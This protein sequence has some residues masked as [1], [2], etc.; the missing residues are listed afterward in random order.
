M[1]LVGYQGELDTDWVWISSTVLGGSS[2]YRYTLIS[3]QGVAEV[4]DDVASATADVAFRSGV[5]R[6]RDVQL[7]LEETSAT[8]EGRVFDGVTI[9]ARTYGRPQLPYRRI[10]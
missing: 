5:Y 9:Q 3:D 2:A 6:T 4:H 7:L 1:G 8:G 10:P